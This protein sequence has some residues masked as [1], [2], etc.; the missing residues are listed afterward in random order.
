MSNLRSKRTW[1]IAVSLLAIGVSTYLAITNFFF[2]VTSSGLIQNKLNQHMQLSNIYYIVLYMHIATGIIALLI[3]W[4]QFIESFRKIAIGFHRI[5][6]KIYSV[7]ILFSGISGLF[8]AFKATGGW[9]STLAFLLLSL[10]WI[11]T[12]IKGYRAIVVNRD[13]R[14]HQKWMLRN[15]ALTFA[16]V[17]LR[18]YLPICMLLFGFEMFE[19]Y[20]R[21]IAW[22]CWIPNLIIAEWIIRRTAH[23]LS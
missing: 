5:I 22:L 2:G 7:C 17:T 8:I 13:Q 20:Y 6:G 14:S 3:G 19:L 16:A 11:Y 1:L 15:Y 10:L 9:I 18:I 4:L 23:R 12:I 21:A